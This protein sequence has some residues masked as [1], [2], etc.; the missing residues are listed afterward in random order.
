MYSNLFFRSILLLLFTT[1]LYAQNLCKEVKGVIVDQEGNSI[2]YAHI[3][4]SGSSKGT[5]SNLEGAFSLS[6]SSR[7]CDQNLQVSATGFELVNVSIASLSEK[8]M[9]KIK[10][11][12]FVT[13]LDEVVIKPKDMREILK[14]ALRKIPENYALEPAKVHGFYKNET[15]FNEK[16]SS[17]VEAALDIYLQG[18]QEKDQK[19]QLQLIKARS[20]KDE[21]VVE[22]F[23]SMEDSMDFE[24]PGMAHEILETSI[25]KDNGNLFGEDEEMTSRFVMFLNPETMDYY[26]FEFVKMTTYQGRS[27]MVINYKPRWKMDLGM[28]EGTI[29]LDEDTKAFARIDY[30]VP[31]SFLKYIVPL[32]GIGKGLL[33]G[34]MEIFGGVS[35]NFHINHIQGSES[36]QYVDQKWY[37]KYKG[38][39][40][41]LFLKVKYPKE[42]INIVS[43]IDF[44]TDFFITDI[45]TENI[46]EIPEEERL[47]R[48]DSLIEKSDDYNDLFWETYPMIPASEDILL[49]MK[50]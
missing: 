41:S 30:N 31:K 12:S 43:D 23:G 7:Y 27:A 46:E 35:F 13:E 20:L 9:N 34:A 28:F 2:P 19:N 15:K 26:S 49:K 29:I 3:L 1:N 14:E 37:P 47:K 25:V 11:K 38:G 6:I 33:I 42:K 39:D 24:M 21:S 22:G 44:K 32:R 45:Q 36:F 4:I 40:F 8:K 48:E 16:T 10:L 18:I 17:Y 5:F 50:M